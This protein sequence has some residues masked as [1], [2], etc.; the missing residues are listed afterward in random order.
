MYGGAAK[1]VFQKSQMDFVVMDL[2]GRVGNI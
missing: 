1:T 2:L